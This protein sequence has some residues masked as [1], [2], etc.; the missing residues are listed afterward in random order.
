MCD[1]SWLTLFF[2]GT[3]VLQRGDDGRPT[4]AALSRYIDWSRVLA[5][6]YFKIMVLFV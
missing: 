5:I 4:I 3:D 6:L 2:A 1:S